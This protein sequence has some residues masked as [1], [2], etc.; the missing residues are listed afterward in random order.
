[1]HDFAARKLDMT[2]GFGVMCLFR[3][4]AAG[5]CCMSLLHLFLACLSRLSFLLVFLH[6]SLA[7]FYL[8]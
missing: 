5:L 8:T 1:M 4:S 2:C 3:V 7:P 6:I